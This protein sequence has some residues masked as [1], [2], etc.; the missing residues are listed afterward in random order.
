MDNPT[1]VPPGRIRLIPF[2]RIIW[3]GKEVIRGNWYLGLIGLHTKGYPREL[4]I[5]L[6]MREF[7]RWSAGTLVVT[8]FVG[9]AVLT[10]FYSR[11]PYNKITYA[12]LI[13]PTR[14]SELRTLRGEANIEEGLAKL[15]AGQYGPA[16]MLLN[17]GLARK[18]DNIPARLVVAQMYTS[19]GYLNRAMQV[20]RAGLPYAGEQR[21]FIAAAIQLAEYTEDYELVLTLVKEA[22]PAVPTDFPSLRTFLQE[23]RILAYE[24]LGRYDDIEALWT[25]NQAAPTM[26]L[27]AAHLRALAATGKAAEAIAA[28]EAKPAQY[29]LLREPWELLLELARIAQNPAAVNR[30]L[31]TL[32][33]LEPTRYRFYVKRIAYLVET[34]AEQAASEQIDSYFLRFGSDP[35]AVVMLL[36]G[37]EQKPTQ[38]A[39]DHIW[40]EISALGLAGPAAHMTYVQNLIKLGALERAQQ[41]YAI[42]CYEIE[43]TKYRDDGWMEGTGILLELMRSDSPSSRSLLQNYAVNRALPPSAFRAMIGSLL[44]AKRLA[45][46][47]EIALLAS[48]R[49]PSIRDLPAAATDLSAPEVTNTVAAIKP[50]D[51]EVSLPLDQARQELASLDAAI[52]SGQWGDALT[53]CIRVEKSPLARELGDQLLSR[54]IKIH[55]HLSN[56]AEL[57]WHMRRLLGLGRL[58]PARLRALAEELNSSGRADSAQTLLREVLRRHPDAKWASDLLRVWIAEV[59]AAPM[60][61]TPAARE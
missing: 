13:L 5:Y 29:G 7:L 51:A 30:A 59:K 27:N 10:W 4:W 49:Y 2:F 18:P 55:G 14:W 46:A 45:A 20:Y 19:M 1:A 6:S 48:N 28:L 17:Q 57:S 52:Q 16:F 24:K 47:R 43:R 42:A 61:V 26:R 35:V 53:R 58:E 34:D 31:D 15:K 12:D 60:S 39:V 50:R 40:R 33:Q 36:K 44:D 21:R 37:I 8:Y 9:A 25:A 11:N 22:E 54:F 32:V 38:Q 23:K 3:G 56:Q 41:Q